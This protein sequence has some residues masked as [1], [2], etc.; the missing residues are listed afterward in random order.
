MALLSTYNEHG[1]VWGG[2]GESL[3]VWKIPASSCVLICWLKYHLY[4]WCHQN[5]TRKPLRLNTDMTQCWNVYQ[6]RIADIFM[7]ISTDSVY[8]SRVEFSWVQF[9]C[10]VMMQSSKKHIFYIGISFVVPTAKIT[11]TKKCSMA[12]FKTKLQNALQDQIGALKSYKGAPFLVSA[13]S[14]AAAFWTSC[15]V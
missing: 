8:S 15:N 3:E 9:Q 2:L 10:F 13:R 7:V 4:V 14:L 11:H 6:Y 12:F 5:A 1:C